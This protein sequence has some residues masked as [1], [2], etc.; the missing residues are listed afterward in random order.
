LKYLFNDPHGTATLAMDATTQ[1]V[2][3]QQ[4]TPYGQQRAS[5]NTT[6]WP[7]PTHSYLGKP[8]DTSTGYTD[9]GARKYDPALGS[10][11]SV[12]PLFEASDPQEL[13]GYAY[14]ADNPVTGSDPTGL[15]SCY[16]HFCSGSNGTYGTYRPENDP[17]SSRYCDTHSCSSGGG[18]S[19]AP[20]TI[21]PTPPKS[22]PPAAQRAWVKSL[23]MVDKWVRMSDGGDPWDDPD[24][25]HIASETFWQAFCNADP[26]ACPVHKPDAK[27]STSFGYFPVLE[28]GDG[29]AAQ[30]AQAAFIYRNLRPDEDPA[31]GLSAKNPEATYSMT[32]HV[33]SGS[34]PNVRTQ[35]ISTT[36]S[37]DVIKKWIQPGGRVAVIDPDK[38]RPDDLADLTTPEAR[39]TYL[40][41]WSAKAYA[42]SSQEV[43]VN[44]HIDES[45]II[46]LLEEGELPGED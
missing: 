40:A 14:A 16:P 36:K 9:V 7:D 4:Y 15:E 27:N 23:H 1:Q 34:K 42:A 21:A 12:D 29:S 19:S 6:A 2:A 38:I 3:R 37:M 43:L 13:G 41:G 22:L 35:W 26:A 31:A 30:L 46:A 11:I 17:G 28:I 24:G 8:Q 32:Y 25:I 20:L 18:A 44:G 10:F 39:D 5:V 45:A 33:G